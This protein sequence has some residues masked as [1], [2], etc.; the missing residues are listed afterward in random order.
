MSYDMYMECEIRNMCAICNTRYVCDMD[1]D[2]LRSGVDFL[3]SEDASQRQLLHMQLDYL[4]RIDVRDMTHV[5][6]HKR[7]LT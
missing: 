2:F 1:V 4:V 3:R 7:D 5:M 6:E